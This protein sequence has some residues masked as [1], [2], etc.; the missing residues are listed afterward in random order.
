ML[1]FLK[2][3]L[4]RVLR[5]KLLWLTLLIGC[6]ITVS[7][8]F[9]NVLSNVQYLDIFQSQ[10]FGTICPHTWYEKWIGGELSTSQSYIYFMLIPILC[11]LPHSTSLAY[12][13]SSGYTYNLFTRGKKVHFYFAK[14]ITTFFSGG[15]VVILP[16]IINLL[17]SICTLPT[18]TPD[19]ATGTS[20][21]T[22]TMFW[23]GL[24]FDY[25][26]AYIALYL[27]I[28]FVFSGVIATFGLI[29]GTAVYNSFLITIMPFV[30]YLFSYAIC[31]MN[32]WH[33]FCPFMFLTPAQR[34]DN[35]TFSTVAVETIII[36]TIILIAYFIQAR[37][38][39]TLN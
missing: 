18:I 11:V 32:G 10:P 19:P 25:P 28:I 23:A 2:I 3:E 7:Q 35:I 26:I 33:R 5:S 13:R 12:D 15:V 31:T 30:T 6:A 29:L 37:R 9:M 20:M 8:Y 34:V 36:L 4:R 21:I 24:Y 16:L 1:A 14:Y 22:G 17:L 27:G 39:E 38:D